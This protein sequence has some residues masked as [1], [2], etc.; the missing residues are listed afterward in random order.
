MW[1]G[2]GEPWCKLHAAVTSLPVID[3][4]S[5]AW[6]AP[7]ITARKILPTLSTVYHS[8]IIFLQRNATLTLEVLHRAALLTLVIFRCLWSWLPR[9]VVHACWIHPLVAADLTW[10]DVEISACPKGWLE[11]NILNGSVL[12]G[13]E[14]FL[15]F[16]IQTKINKK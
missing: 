8:L 11:L 9:S 16:F 15:I 12:L 14:I 7:V 3:W 10:S 4:L 6:W 1:P 13:T 2:D 5:V